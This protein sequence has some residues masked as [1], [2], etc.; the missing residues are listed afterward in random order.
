MS[1]SAA[2]VRRVRHWKAKNRLFHS[3]PE[4]SAKIPRH[5]VP[6]YCSEVLGRLLHKGSVSQGRGKACQS[7]QTFTSCICLLVHLFQFKGKVSLIPSL[8]PKNE[9]R[10]KGKA[11]ETCS[12]YRPHLGRVRGAVWGFCLGSVLDEAY[13]WLCTH[14]AGKWKHH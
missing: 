12:S 6:L 3:H 7:A 2:S 14:A 10:R 11:K 4:P 1:F 5:T 8:S 9:W 13:G